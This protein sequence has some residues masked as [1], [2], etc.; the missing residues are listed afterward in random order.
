A[1][2]QAYLWGEYNVRLYAKYRAHG[3][4]RLT[5]QDGAR[6]WLRLLR[7]VR[8]LADRHKR[9]QW[10]WRLSWRLGRISGSIKYRLLGR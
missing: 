6:Q 2:R 1:L 7:Q 8:W 9:E 3:M 5:L 4:P 10:L